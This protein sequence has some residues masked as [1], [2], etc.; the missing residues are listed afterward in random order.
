MKNV[1]KLIVVA[2]AIGVLGTAGTALAATFKTP[3]D[4]AAEVTGQSVETVT[5]QRISSG[6]SYGTIANEAGKLDEFQSQ[7]L[8]QRKAILDERVQSGY[9]T[10]EQ[11]DQIYEAMKNNQATCNGQGLKAGGCGWG[12]GCGLGLGQGNG[13][14]AGFGNRGG[15]GMGAG[16]RT[17]QNSALNQ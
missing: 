5:E 14:A 13:S 10:Q 17:G 9:L 12:A 11:A 15:R 4:I 2:T 7:M 6:K 16:Q 1:K 8:E 3:A